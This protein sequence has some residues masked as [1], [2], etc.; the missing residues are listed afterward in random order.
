MDVECVIA[1]LAVPKSHYATRHPQF[2]V[3]GPTDKY[4]ESPR[5][6]V[7]E[8]FDAPVGE[9][10]DWP[11]ED[12]EGLPVFR[13]AV[14]MGTLLY[15]AT[16]RSFYCIFAGRAPPL[17]FLQLEPCTSPDLE[18]HF[19]LV[20]GAEGLTGR[21]YSY[22]LR[23]L[24]RF[25]FQYV[26]WEWP[27]KWEVKKTR[28]GRLYR[29]DLGF[30]TQ[31]LLP[32][33]PLNGCWWAWTNIPKFE[34]ARLNKRVRLG[35]N[36][37]G[38][39]PI[40]GAAA[41]T[42]GAMRHAGPQLEGKSAERFLNLIDWLVDQGIATEKKWL[43][44]D[45]DGYRSFLS[46]S[47]GVLQAKNAL[48]IAR[49][50]MVLSQPLVRYLAKGGAWDEFD[51]KLCDIFRLNGYEPS[52]V[53]RY[54]ACWAVG[55]WPKRRALW[56]WGPASTGKTVIA[57]AIAAQAPSYG[58]VNWTNAN[59]PFNDC[60]CQP[61]VWWEEGRMTE[62]IVEV[63]KAILG[64]SPVRLDVKNKGSEDFLPTAVIITSNGDLTVTVDGPVISDAHQDALRTRMCMIRLERV[65]PA[66]LAPVEPGDIHGFFKWG[67]DLVAVQG[68]PAEVFEVPRRH[69][70]E[71]MPN[72]EL[73]PR[74]LAT[75]SAQAAGDHSEA[76]TW[77]SEEEWF[78]RTNRKRR[79]SSSSEEEGVAEK[80]VRSSSVC[81][82]SD[83]VSGPFPS[84][85]S[86]RYGYDCRWCF[87]ESRGRLVDAVTYAP[88]PAVICGK[89]D[90]G[91]W[92][93]NR[94]LN[95]PW[96]LR[97]PL[98]RLEAQQTRL[99]DTISTWYVEKYVNKDSV[100]Y[101]AADS[102]LHCQESISP[103]QY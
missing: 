75:E 59:F 41:G 64:G 73:L 65:L 36:T 35:W 18:Y 23:Q 92:S 25:M 69:E 5:S 49:R 2:W 98:S 86:R 58:C 24:G 10:D 28:Q 80:R 27:Y 85:E 9:S 45:R 68:T 67:A 62:N 17:V 1:V 46:S 32:K 53:A 83:W 6:M 100:F 30:V 103:E 81:S 90:K 3:K 70:T 74:D 11:T 89:A 22:W 57:A 4:W 19:H 84:E 20:V 26:S 38:A 50:E 91:R 78:A 97:L 52:L 101:S 60:H 42:S 43:E 21:D 47:G 54:M 102:C 61:L 99:K 8:R 93:V 16:I 7:G 31:Y 96:E 94:L 29:A 72:I 76:A 63:A 66:H 13:D 77:S 39:I 44:A 56:L 15:T 37:G 12:L 87:L 55:H 33:V 79:F 48:N 95:R 34:A 88:Y 71:D 40:E 51:S 82:V 14:F